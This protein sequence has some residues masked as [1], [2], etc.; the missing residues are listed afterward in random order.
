MI[1]VGFCVSYDWRLLKNSLPRVYASADVICLSI[2]KSRRSWSGSS[3]T[4]DEDDFRKWLV[5]ADPD[6]KIDFYEDDF[7]LPNLTAMQNDSRQRNMM[8]ARMG[9][10]GWHIQVDSDEYFVDFQGFVNYLRKLLPNPTGDEKPFNVHVFLY[11]L[12]KKVD[13]G[14]LVIDPERKRPFSAPFATT[15]PDYWSARQNGHFNKL[16][17]YYVVHE[18]WARGEE[19]L[20]FKLANWGHASVELQKKDV[21]ESYVNFWKSI[22]R[23]NYQFIRDFHFAIPHCWDR[24][25]FVPGE[26]IDELMINFKPDFRIST[27]YIQLANLRA[28]GKMKQWFSKLNIKLP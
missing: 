27:L 10:G 20:R 16:S 26:T 6:K 15:R 18:T 28:Y 21:R 19:E 2:D 22:D 13:G 25:G 3:Y 23:H 17:P 8:A 9:K 11:D 1:K 4:F 14:Y 24:L 7:A 5:L 12:F